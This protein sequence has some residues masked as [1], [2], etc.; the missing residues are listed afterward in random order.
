[1]SLKLAQWAN[2]FLSA[3]TGPLDSYL[4]NRNDKVS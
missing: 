1:M 4:P 2:E 3:S